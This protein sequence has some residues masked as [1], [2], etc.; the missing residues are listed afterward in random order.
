MEVNNEKKKG[1]ETPKSEK[2]KEEDVKIFKAKSMTDGDLRMPSALRKK[3]GWLNAHT[4][5]V[6]TIVTL[7]ANSITLE[8]KKA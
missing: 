7:D 4:D 3:I 2:P 6:F 1:E 8:I 5:V